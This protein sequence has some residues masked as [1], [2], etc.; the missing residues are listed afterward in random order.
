MIC[1]QPLTV[2]ASSGSAANQGRGAIRVSQRVIAVID[3][4]GNSVTEP[5]KKDPGG[6]WGPVAGSE[7]AGLLRRYAVR[8]L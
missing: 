2:C 1:P 8:S 3:K 4:R 7:G 5:V 6:V